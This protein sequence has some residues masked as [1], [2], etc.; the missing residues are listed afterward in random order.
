VRIDQIDREEPRLVELAADLVEPLHG[1]A[2]RRPVIA[3][4][5]PDL[6]VRIAVDIEVGEAEGFERLVGLRI[7]PVAELRR[8]R[9]VA[10]M[11]FALVGRVVAEIA[12]MMPDRAK[13]RVELREGRRAV[14]DHHVGLLRVAA[15]IDDGARGRT[16]RRVD[17]VFAEEGAALMHPVMRGEVE[18]ARQRLRRP[19]LIGHDEEDVRTFR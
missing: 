9:K 4:A 19:L 15:E 11:P 2:H 5:V 16:G 6:A 17:V 1:G 13:V 10:Q 7:G 18:R 3:I 12:Q 8:V 14:I